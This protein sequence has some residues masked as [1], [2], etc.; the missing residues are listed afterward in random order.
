ML[1]KIIIGIL[2]Y[3]GFAVGV[4]ILYS[5]IMARSTDVTKEMAR[6]DAPYTLILALIWPITLSVCIIVIVWETVKWIARNFIHF[7]KMISDR[8]YD[9]SA[10]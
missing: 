9:D 3:L 5:L 8:V 2:W 4:F 6:E 10:K 1:L 7:F